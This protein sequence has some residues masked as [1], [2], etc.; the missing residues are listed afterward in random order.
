MEL[1]ALVSKTI[2]LPASPTVGYLSLDGSAGA[3]TVSSDMTMKTAGVALLNL[4]GDNVINSPIS[5]IGGSVFTRVTSDGGS[6]NLAGGVSAET[7]SE[8][9]RLELTGTS[10]GANTIS[11]QISDGNSRVDILKTGTGIWALTNAENNYT[12][13]TSVSGGT[14]LINGDNSS[15]G[16]AVNV[17]SEATLGGEGI[18]GGATTIL[19]GGKLAVGDDGV[20]IQTFASG[21]TVDSGGIFDW[22]LAGNTTSGRG[23]NFDGVDVTGTLSI[24]SNSIFRVIQNAGLDFADAFWA[25]NRQWTDIFS[26]GTLASAWNNTAVSVYDTSNVQQNV[27]TYGSFSITGDA[28][29]WTAVPEPSNALSLSWGLPC[30]CAA[31]ARLGTDAFV[32]L[33]LPEA[34]TSSFLMRNPF[35]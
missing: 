10:T 12:G 1:L 19:S 8:Y 28:L 34:A 17:Q 11:G 29:S 21:L 25:T 6:L 33:R 13:G 4:A 16:G 14:L 22:D 3:I 26:A 20:G 7:E 27:S 30:L 18:V 9:R 32:F 31:A 15:A 23:T 24:E 2:I 35:P 5:I